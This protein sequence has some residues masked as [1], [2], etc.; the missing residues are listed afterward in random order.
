MIVPCCFPLCA[1]TLELLSRHVVNF[2]VTKQRAH[3][4]RK[5]IGNFIDDSG[6]CPAFGV[7]FADLL[8]VLYHVATRSCGTTIT[9]GKF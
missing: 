6:I 2:C 3:N 8:R 4:W 5:P 9:N 1:V 7:K